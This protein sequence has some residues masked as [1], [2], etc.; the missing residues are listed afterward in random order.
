M[1][2]NDF[3][4]PAD[5]EAALDVTNDVFPDD[6]NDSVGENNRPDDRDDSCSED[7]DVT[8]RLDCRDV[9][10][11]DVLGHFVG[12]SPE[13]QQ[14][15]EEEIEHGDGEDDHTNSGKS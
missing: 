12:V 14:E 6:G 11:G 9:T 1:A 2:G 3:V 8:Q 5:E 7:T 10:I 15:A 13:K 4:Y